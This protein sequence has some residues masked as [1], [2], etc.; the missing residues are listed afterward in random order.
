MDRQWIHVE[1]MDKLHFNFPP[2]ERTSRFVEGLAGRIAN[3]AISRRLTMLVELM[4]RASG[5]LGGRTLLL[6]N[7]ADNLRPRCQGDCQV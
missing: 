3:D 6:K 7:L 4:F 2:T 1:P 5:G